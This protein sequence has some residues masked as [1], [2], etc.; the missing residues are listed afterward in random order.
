MEAFSIE[1]VVR[2]SDDMAVRRRFDARNLVILIVLAV[3]FTIVS[4]IQFAIALGSQR[5]GWPN[6]VIASITILLNIGMAFLLRDVFRIERAGTTGHWA[7]ARFIQKHVGATTIAF[8]MIEYLLLVAYTARVGDWEA[9]T[10]LFPFAVLAIR[11]LPSELILL[12]SF[13]FG[14]ALLL[15][16][17]DP[18]ASKQRTPLLISIAVINAAC[19]TVELLLSRR[20]RKEII[21]DWTSRRAQAVDQIRMRDELQYA[22][23][24][25]MSMIPETAPQLE[26]LDLA[27]ISVPATEVGGDYFDY[28]IDGPRVA[29]VSADVA[30]HGL[31]SGLVLASL[32]SGF[33]LLRASLSDPSSVLTRLHDLVAYTTRRRILA[34]AAVVLIDRDAKRATIASAGHPPILLRSNGHVRAIEIF[35]PPLG[36]RL[37][38]RIPQV[39]FDVQSGDVFVLHTDGIYEAQNAREESYGMDRLMTVVRS[40]QDASASSMRDAIV[41]DVEKFRAG[42][43]QLDDIT[44][45]VARIV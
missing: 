41:A 28:F 37:P 44:V 31:S 43:R 4:C 35:A 40:H 38:T 17:L 23:E 14:S 8:L 11:L 26:W 10:I 6:V 34:T 5:H 32:R 25:Q 13:L 9:W 45:V 27:G 1:D 19:L 42:A 39:Q 30:G 22:R 2:T 18:T 15:G 33:T 7:A 16:F 36:V 3:F 24:L 12:H 20:M 29:I 21:T